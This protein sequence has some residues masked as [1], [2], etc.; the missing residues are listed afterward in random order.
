[1]ISIKSIAFIDD[2]L[3]SGKVPVRPEDA[4]FTQQPNNRRRGS[5]RP[6]RCR[7]STQN[8]SAGDELDRNY[9]FSLVTG[10]A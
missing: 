1:M 5:P 4:A 2:Q 9:A 7:G 6:A 10:A 3:A 8:I